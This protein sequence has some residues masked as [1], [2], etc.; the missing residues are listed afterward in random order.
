MGTKRKNHPTRPIKW[1]AKF[2]K[3]AT[4]ILRDAFVRLDESERFLND[5]TARRDD[6][7]L[8]DVAA[9]RRAAAGPIDESPF[10]SEIRDYL[11]DADVLR[12]G[13]DFG[14]LDDAQKNALL[15]QLV[16]DAR[17]NA[18]RRRTQRARRGR[19]KVPA[20]AVLAAF[21]RIRLECEHDTDAYRLVAKVPMRDQHGN[22]LRDQHGKL[23]YVSASTVY[24]RVK[25]RK[26]RQAGRKL[27]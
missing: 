12:P 16:R 4:A 3:A 25:E 21:E 7:T 23:V 17:Q 24:N 22:F 13:Q 5:L 20:E 14:D 19:L 2:Q 6:L 26:G 10:A 8:D 18:A 1:P 11:I 15:L 9:L 27:M